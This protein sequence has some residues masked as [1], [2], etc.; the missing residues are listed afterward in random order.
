MMK[1]RMVAL[2]TCTAVTAVL[3]GSITAYAASTTTTVTLTVPVKTAYTMTIPAATAVSDY[4]WTELASNLKVTGTLAA[5]KQVVA[6]ITSDNDYK[7]VNADKSQSIA[8]ALKQSENGDEVSALVFQSK[9]LGDDGKP[10]GVYVEQAA[11]NAVPGGSYSDVLTFT[12]E[13]AN[14]EN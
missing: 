10:L 14:A 2:L 6:T 8:Y 9:D 12:A 1:K 4:G 3:A 7:F 13:T 5:G 11:W